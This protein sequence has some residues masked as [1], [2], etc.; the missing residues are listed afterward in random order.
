VSSDD[1]LEVGK[2]NYHGYQ[3]VP[4]AGC[5]VGTL[6]DVTRNSVSQ[7]ARQSFL[8]EQL[9]LL[10]AASE[11]YSRQMVGIQQGISSKLLQLRGPSDAGNHN[12]HDL[13]KNATPNDEHI[14][15]DF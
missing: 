4:P 7:A 1:F 10:A 13:S 12:T 6:G 14:Q 3:Q 15:T 9:R 2:Y 8:R 5:R 11:E